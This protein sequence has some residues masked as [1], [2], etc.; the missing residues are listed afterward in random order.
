MAILILWKWSANWTPKSKIFCKK[1]VRLSTIFLG[2]DHNC[3][4]RPSN[5]QIRDSLASFRQDAERSLAAVYCCFQEIYGDRAA[6]IAAEVCLR[7]FVT[8]LDATGKEDRLHHRFNLGSH[9]FGGNAIWCLQP[10]ARGPEYRPGGRGPK[11]RGIDAGRALRDVPRL[12]GKYP[13]PRG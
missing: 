2:E 8:N 9:L 10:T 13:P 7:I 11:Q 5:D 1:T 6:R 12:P 3:T 4:H